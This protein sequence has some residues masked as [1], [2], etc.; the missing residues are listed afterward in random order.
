MNVPRPVDNVR[1]QAIF[2]VGSDLST[3]LLEMTRDAPLCAQVL[4]SFMRDRDTASLKAVKASNSTGNIPVSAQADGKVQG[5]ATGT[6]HQERGQAV[7]ESATSK[8]T[9]DPRATTR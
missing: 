9:G 4:S 2:V 5:T 8:A 7:T 3:R 6:P 1:Q